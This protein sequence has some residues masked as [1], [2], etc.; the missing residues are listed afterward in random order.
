[1]DVVYRYYNRWTLKANVGKCV[2][3]VFSNNRV[4]GR[5]KWREHEL[6]VTWHRFCK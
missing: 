2:V 4:E 3:M 5:W 1:M 6:Q